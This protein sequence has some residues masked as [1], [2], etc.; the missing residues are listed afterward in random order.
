MSEVKNQMNYSEIVSVDPVS[1]N[2]YKYVKNEIQ[3]CN[4]DKSKKD[5][6]FTS[7]IPSKYIISSTVELSRNIPDSDLK[8]AIEI[9]VYDELGLDSTINYKIIYF[10]S[11]TNDNKNKFFN[12]FVI[13]GSKID[14]LLLNIKKKTHYIDYVT[15]APFLIKS[16]YKKSFIDSDSI[17]CFVYFQHND[18]FLAI[19]RGENIYTLSHFIIR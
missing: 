6:F 10:E 13:D 17:D 12:V 16:L 1:H 11:E 4:I 9:K 5:S 18:A 7:Y 2:S 14:E 15:T 3:L 8:D 19:Y